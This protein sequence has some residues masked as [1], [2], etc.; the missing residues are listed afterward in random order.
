MLERLQTAA[1]AAVERV[2]ALHIKGAPRLMVYLFIIIIFSAIGAFLA[3]W[4]FNWWTAGKADL[5]VMIQF[6]GAGSSVSF[7]AAVA[8]FGRALIDSDDDGIPDE[9][10]PKE[11]DEN[12]ESK[13]RG[14]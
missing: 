7:V 9:F 13:R 3:G 12:A 10:Q 5:P 14:R 11:G 1:R 8:F 6:L 2:A 4:C